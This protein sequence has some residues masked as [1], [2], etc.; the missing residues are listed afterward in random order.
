M[1]DTTTMTS[2][3]EVRDSESGGAM[4]SNGSGMDPMGP[5]GN[6]IGV[7][8]TSLNGED[9]KMIGSPSRLPCGREEEKN[10]FTVG[11]RVV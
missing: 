4:I 6:H 2:T 5:G 3:H 10:P 8:R 9:L 11:D 1:I 7:G